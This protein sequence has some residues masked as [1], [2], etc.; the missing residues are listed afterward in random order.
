MSQRPQERWNGR[1]P[2]HLGFELRMKIDGT[3]KSIL[4]GSA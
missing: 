2:Y 3:Y 1:L 4:A